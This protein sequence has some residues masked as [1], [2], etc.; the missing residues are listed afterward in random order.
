MKK[1]KLG[2]ISSKG[3]HLY[4]LIQIRSVWK[5]LD[6]FWITFPGKD[7][8]SY[9]KKQ[10]KYYAAYPESRNLINFIKNLFLAF[11]ILKKER[12]TKLLSCGAGIAVPFFLV[13]KFIFNT[14][15][16]YIESYD[17]I[18]YPSLTGRILYNMVD[19]FLV[20]HKNQLKWYPK[21]KFWGSLL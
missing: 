8:E 14:K 18:A 1:T 19:L 3:G 11:K 4:E 9:L 13:G 12:P 10:K 6:N 17:F 16:I 5:R 20:Q 21:A 7:T 15:L 2:L